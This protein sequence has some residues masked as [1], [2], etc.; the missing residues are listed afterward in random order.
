MHPKI[1]TRVVY[2][3]SFFGVDLFFFLT[4]TFFPK[5]PKNTFNIKHVLS[6]VQNFEF[7][8][9]YAAQCATVSSQNDST[10]TSTFSPDDLFVLGV[11]IYKNTPGFYYVCELWSWFIQKTLGNED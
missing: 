2:I 7:S 6:I 11:S 9:A 10:K 4:I 3:K 8:S 5:F 1:C